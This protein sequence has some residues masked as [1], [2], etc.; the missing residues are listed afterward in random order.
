MVGKVMRAGAVILELG[1][2]AAGMG[3]RSAQAD[4][5]I[6]TAKESKVVCVTTIKGGRTTTDCIGAEEAVEIKVQTLP[7]TTSGF[8]PM[9]RICDPARPATLNSGLVCGPDGLVYAPGSGNG[10]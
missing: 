1:A 4:T 10:G 8:A 5:T 2:V 3:L 6:I 9:Q 7:A